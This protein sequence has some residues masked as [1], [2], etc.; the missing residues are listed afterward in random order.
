MTV[1]RRPLLAGIATLLATPA[2]AQAPAWPSRTVRIVVAYPAG[3]SVDI[4][5][6][7][8]AEKLGALWGQPVIVENRGGASGTVGAEH[9]TKSAPDGTTLL[10]GASPELAI[11]RNTIRNMPFDVTGDFAPIILV[12]EAPFILVGLPG[13]PATTT[14][15]LVALAKARPGTMNYA[16]S[17]NGTSS[18]LTGALFA[19]EAGIDITHVPYR[20]SGALMS[21]LIGGQV[22][23]TFDT[24]PTTLPH[25]RDGRLRAFGAAMTQRSTLMPEL[26]T[27]AEAGLP[28]VL[29]GSW[30]GL[31]APAGTPQP[32]VQKIYADTARVMQDSISA[33]LRERGFEPR[34]LPPAEFS[35]FIQ[36]EV[37]KWGDVASR[38]GVRPDQSWHQFPLPM[39]PLPSTRRASPL[40]GHE[41]KA[42]REDPMSSPPSSV[43]RFFSRPPS[44]TIIAP[45]HRGTPERI[46]RCRVAPRRERSTLSLDSP[47]RKEWRNI[48]Q[49]CW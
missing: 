49:G 46:P 4:A 29:G 31:L 3:G 40:I 35:G 47:A 2:L 9:V 7:L 14:Q 41:H 26:P 15:A 10:T 22:Q 42:F 11:A 16:S 38:A 8:L 13:L 19:L 34:G 1:T 12:N 20:G 43:T 6:R 44:T 36:A 25:I 28:K 45:K 37:A 30:S 32:V 23:L 48:D 5:A 24:I 27:F 21:D 18:H 33:T 17:G 39:R